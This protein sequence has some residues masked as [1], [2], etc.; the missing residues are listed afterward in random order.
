[1]NDL[2][3]ERVSELIRGVIEL[4][5]KR[6]DGLAGSEVIA[7][8]PEI[9]HLTE[10][11]SSFLSSSYLPRYART[12]R[13]ATLPLMKAGWLMKTDKGL[14]L[15]TEDG[16]DACRRFSR[17]SD[18]F[19]EALRLSNDDQKNIPEILVSL[20]LTQEEAWDV[21]ANYI[22][23]KNTIEIRRLIAGL[24]E[25]MQYHIVWVA[26][27]QKKR[28]LI[29]MVANVDPV[30]AK[31]QRILIQV[32]HSGQPVTVEGLKSFSSVL[33]VND[34]G[35]LFSTGGF[36][37]EVR[38]V[39]NKG[40][41]QKINAMDLAKFYDLWIKHYEKLSREAHTLLPLRAIFFLSPPG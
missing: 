2:S 22:R 4:L 7:R 10:Y 17:P 20:E 35:L 24:F 41:Y 29:D 33:G 27:P 37:S 11:E 3:L 21:I 31:A 14:W 39:L 15:I 30:G 26:P 38:D 9:V 32:K 36:T 5:W 40:D 18:L 16:R 8:L 19:S 28:G 13:L 23:G 25:A 6:P 34:F 12:V 1:M